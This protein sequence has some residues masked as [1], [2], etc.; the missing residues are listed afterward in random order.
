L[1]KHIFIYAYTNLN[2]GDDLFIKILCDQ[3]PFTKFYIVSSVSKSSALY[4]IENLGVIPRIPYIDEIFK[5]L[6]IRININNVI[7]RL[8]SKQCDAIVNIGG[9]IFIENKG[10]EERAHQFKKRLIPNKPYFIIS[11]NFGPYANQAFYQEYKSIFNSVTDICFR[12]EYS[13]TL[14]SEINHVRYASDIV[15]SYHSTHN[16]KV[17][18]QVTISVI[19]LSKRSDLKAYSK[20]YI[21]K[22]IEISK[23]LIQDGYQVC[24][25]GFCSKQGDKKVINEIMSHFSDKESIFSHNYS[26]NIEESLN[27]IKESQAMIATRF[28]AM[29]LG[30]VF[31]KPVYPIIYSNKT[32][33]VIKDVGFKG[34]YTEISNIRNINPNEIIESILEAIPFDISN[35]IT[36]SNLE[37]EKLDT[38]LLN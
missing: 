26:G 16:P 23:L 1:S 38:F 36:S 34:K 15:F 27:I 21:D 5:R 35:Q 28:H 20:E 17:K 24:L 12:E 18:K 13:Y 32:L 31:N 33:N 7:Q 6:G 25:M 22:I 8:L 29:I 30:W 4:K 9:S 3:Y 11:S 10:W 14:F 37:F 2:L 19:D